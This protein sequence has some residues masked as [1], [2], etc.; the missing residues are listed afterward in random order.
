MGITMIEVFSF[1]FLQEYK[2]VN[3]IRPIKGEMSSNAWILHLRNISVRKANLGAKKLSKRRCLPR[4]NAAYW[5]FNR[6]HLRSIRSANNI[7]FIVDN[8]F[9]TLSI[10]HV[11]SYFS[12]W[13][14]AVVLLSLFS[15]TFVSVLNSF[16]FFPLWKCVFSMF[17]FAF[18]SDLFLF[19]CCCCCCC[20]DRFRCQIQIRSIRYSM[21][22]I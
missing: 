18:Q 9:R 15:Q 22:H 8:L 16:V 1:C 19:R 5:P 21:T 14:A 3:G 13:I 2:M 20:N 4:A 10:I 12:I 6:M 17:C 7:R 11:I